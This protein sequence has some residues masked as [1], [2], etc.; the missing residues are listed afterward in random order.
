[1]N[2]KNNMLRRSKPVTEGK[3][4][5]IYEVSKIVK[6]IEAESKNGDCWGWE[7]R[8]AVVQ[9]VYGIKMSK[10]WRSAIKPSAY[11]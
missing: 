6:L 3:M 5:C 7:K 1:M 4:L 11:S 8:R 10:F 2:L 9:W